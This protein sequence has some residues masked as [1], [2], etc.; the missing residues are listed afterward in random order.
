MVRMAGFKGFVWLMRLLVVA[1]AWA[2]VGCGGEAGTGRED[3]VEKTGTASQALTAAQAR[4][5]SFEAPTEDWKT[6]TGVAISPSS[7]AS[8]GAKA[9]SLVPN[10]YTEVISTTLRAPGG[11][12]ST[13]TVDVRLSQALTFGEVRLVMRAPSAGMWWTDFGVVSLAGRP[14]NTYQTLSFTV[15]QAAKTVLNGTP[16]T[17]IFALF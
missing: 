16:T 8:H 4:V 11:A 7:T 17:W 14:A 15:P 5:F 13:A 10:G 3:A 6:S 9:L 12:L 2:L 1:V